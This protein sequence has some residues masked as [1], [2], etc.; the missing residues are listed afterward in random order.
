M[1]GLRRR[2]VVN[3]AKSVLTPVQAARLAGQ[4]L[5]RRGRRRQYLVLHMTRGKIVEYVDRVV[6][7]GGFHL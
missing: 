1:N 5:G 7:G 3:V 2:L 6:G 4:R